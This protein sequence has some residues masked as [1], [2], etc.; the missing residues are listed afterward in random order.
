MH[1]PTMG[2][3]R[4]FVEYFLPGSAPVAAQPVGPALRTMKHTQNSDA[5]RHQIDRDVR[6]ARDDQFARPLHPA[7]T[8]AVWEVAQLGNGG[9]D[10]LIDSNRRTRIFR[11]D[12]SKI[13]FRSARA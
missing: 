5:I 11:L 7:P 8:A 9:R 6:C 3:S 12:V 13:R 1:L 4:D 10:T 2:G